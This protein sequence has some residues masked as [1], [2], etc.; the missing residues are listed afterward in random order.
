MIVLAM[1]QCHYDYAC[2][3]WFS[4]ISIS[5]KKGLQ[6]VQN[7]VIRFVLGFLPRTHLGC[8]EFSRVNILPVKYRADQIKL[9]HMFNI[10]HGSAPEYLKHSI[11]LSRSNR[12][13]TRS[14]NLSCVMLSVE[15]FG[16]KSFFYSASKLWNSLSPNRQYITN[17]HFVVAHVYILYNMLLFISGCTSASTLTLFIRILTFVFSQIRFDIILFFLQMLY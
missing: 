6:T 17:K 10:V 13:N 1:V 15:G 3:M 9:N 11:N 8:S 4:R 16:I 7:K 2:A 12:Y 14:G 5:A